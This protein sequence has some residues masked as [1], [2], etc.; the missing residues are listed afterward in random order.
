MTEN[1]WEIGIRAWSPDDD[2]MQARWEHYHVN[3][4][5]KNIAVVK[6]LNKAKYGVNS[7]IGIMDSYEIYMVEGPYEK[8]D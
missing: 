5:H 8:I 4:K 1:L 3:A 2:E 6:A 7:V